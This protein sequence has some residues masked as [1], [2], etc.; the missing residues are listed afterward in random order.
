MKEKLKNINITPIIF[1]LY[2]IIY[3]ELISRIFITKSPFGIGV[4][5]TI[6]FSLPII[7]LLTL[8]SK[9]FN[10]RVNKIIMIIITLT[11]TIY[12]QTQFIFLE[13]FPEPFAFTTIGLADQAI[14][15]FSIA[16]NEIKKHFL[17]FIS[18]F[19]PFITLIVF[20]KK[21]DTK[22]YNKYTKITLGIMCII[23]YLSTYITLIPIN[24][25]TINT[26][27]SYYNTS[28]S[29]LSI[30]DN[31]GMLTYCR[32]D[33]SRLLFGKKNTTKLE[34]I[35]EEIETIP[36]TKEFKKNE[37]PLDFIPSDN[38]QINQL[39]E[40]FSTIEGTYQN[41]FTGMFKDKNL[42]FILAEGFNEIAVDKNRTP[43][44]YKMINEGFVFE[45]FYSPEFLSTTGGEFQA[46]SGLVP[47]QEILS[48]WKNETPNIPY[49]IGN[50]FAQNGYRTQAY[51]NWT[52]KYYKRHNT[53][54]TLG[55]SNYIGC[56]NG[57]EKHMSCGWLTKDTELID[58]T[59]PWYLGQGTKFA[60]YYI[61]LSG[62]AEYSK[63]HNVAK[64]YFEQVK[65]LPYSEGI[66]YY[67]ASQ[68]ELD[69]SLDLLLKKLKESG[70]LDN[71][72]IALVGD[73]YPYSLE[74]E[75]INEV[76]TY[77]KDDTIEVNH[78][79]FIIWNNK[80]EEPIKI[81]KVGSQIDVLPTLLNLFGIEY[82]SRLIVGKDILSTNEGIAIFSDHSWVTDY[83]K[84]NY[85][86]NTFIPKKDKLLEDQK[87]YINKINNKV[88]NAFSI[89]RMIIDTNYYTYILNK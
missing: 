12:F 37:L 16:I 2:L 82:D 63:Y 43:T 6:I 10:D 39:N 24:K 73:H 84:Y 5:Y 59:T 8:I 41:E 85:R 83:G 72:V 47:T 7:I 38:S 88:N 15:N 80:M 58:V 31:F 68:I 57:L 9:L 11:I 20:N 32:I 74:I 28:T 62:H 21:I 42:I 18:I 50:S 51:H 26:N 30:I 35:E 17:L 55:F 86:T 14:D 44:L 56:G 29:K 22:Q 33:I 89:S 3:L 48:K 49:A 54:N 70:E 87:E 76:S 71:T 27:N 52:Y 40:Y 1:Y 23:L 34:V 61:T 64:E 66:K 45:N 75:E 67:L 13:L 81:N 60:T 77:Q 53:M 4:L 25:V 36:E 65:N 19:I 79:N 78:S 46:V 69:R